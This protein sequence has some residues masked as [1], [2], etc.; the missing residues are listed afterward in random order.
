MKQ[1]RVRSFGLMIDM[2]MRVENLIISIDD[3]VKS[4]ETGDSLAALPELGQA[5]YEVVNI[6]SK[7]DN[8]QSTIERLMIYD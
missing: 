1:K 5:F 4:H 8:K 6:Q 2:K 3:F 7:I